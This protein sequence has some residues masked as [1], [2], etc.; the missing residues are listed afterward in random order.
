MSLCW[1]L[2][3]PQKSYF[4]F[5]AVYYNG[6][7]ILKHAIAFADLKDT[8][9]TTTSFLW[10]IDWLHEAGHNLQYFASCLETD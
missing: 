6:E 5:K 4:C 9:L 2:Y 8:K 3:E 1:K 7:N 10:D